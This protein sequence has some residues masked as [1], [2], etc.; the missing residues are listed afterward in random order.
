MNKKGQAL[1]EFVIILPLI[2]F[3][4]LATIDIGKIFYTKNNLENKLNDVVSMYENDTD[5][6]KIERNLKKDIKNSKLKISE[7][8]TDI[9]FEI[10]KKVEIITPGLNLIFKN[11]YEVKVKRVINNEN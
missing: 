1:V 4:L 2:V 5:I 8:N 9:K 7:D 11:P 10:T 3:M 6:K